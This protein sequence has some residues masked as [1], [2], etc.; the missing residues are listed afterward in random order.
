MISEPRGLDPELD[1]VTLL[2]K[3]LAIVILVFVS[4]WNVTKLPW[5]LVSE[6]K[7]PATNVT[8]DPIRCMKF[9]PQAGRYTDRLKGDAGPWLSLNLESYST[10]I[11]SIL[12]RMEIVSQE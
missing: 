9:K 10:K 3:C 12:E 11:E 4:L 1:L 6:D 8:Y 2:L 5:F 7:Y